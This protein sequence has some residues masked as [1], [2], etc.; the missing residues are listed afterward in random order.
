MQRAHAVL[1]R[2]RR[3]LFAW[4]F[5]ALAV[6]PVWIVVGWSVFAPTRPALELD[7]TPVLLVLAAVV[8]QTALAVL[9]SLRRAVRRERAL[10]WSDAV[11]LVV[12]TGELIEAGFAG[13]GATTDLMV[14]LVAYAVGYWVGV[15]ELVRETRVRIR[16][17]L[18]ALGLSRTPAPPVRR[19]EP[20]VAPAA[21]R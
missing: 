21:R 3:V 16:S 10:S 15:V 14:A 20:V 12:A 19:G 17:A 1:D 8:A 4:Q 9:F 6:V 13:T 5:A 7:L 2:V 18:D 11:V